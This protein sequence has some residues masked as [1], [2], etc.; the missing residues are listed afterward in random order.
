MELLQRHN[1]FNVRQN[2]G[3]HVYI[4]HTKEEITLIA[5]RNVVASAKR[6]DFKYTELFEN[7]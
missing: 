4:S 6:Y 7:K 1:G 5:E 3:K 2:I